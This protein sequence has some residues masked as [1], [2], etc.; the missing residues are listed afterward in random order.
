LWRG[1]TGRKT[2]RQRHSHTKTGRETRTDG[3]RDRERQRKTERE[4]ER[5]QKRQRDGEATYTLDVIKGDDVLG[6]F[7]PDLCHPA[8][9]PTCRRS[10]TWALMHAKTKHVKATD[11]QQHWLDQTGWQTDRQAETSERRTQTVPK[12]ELPPARSSMSWFMIKTTTSSSTM[13][14]TDRQTETD[15]SRQTHST[16]ARAAACPL[17]HELVHDEDDDQQQHDAAH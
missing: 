15:A 1:K 6:V 3:Y 11:D 13:L 4:R 17:L 10:Q 16:E 12:R 5:G 14:R 8:D 2:W 9:H 7:G